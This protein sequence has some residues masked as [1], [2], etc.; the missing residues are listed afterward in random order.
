MDMYKEVI[1][2]KISYHIKDCILYDNLVYENRI[3]QHPFLCRPYG[4]IIVQNKQL[5]YN[6]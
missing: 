2:E 6:N 5:W 4:V 1:D 3:E